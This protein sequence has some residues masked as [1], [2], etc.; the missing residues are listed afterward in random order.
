MKE[1][2]IYSIAVA[3][4]C[5][6]FS[7]VVQAQF[8]DKDMRLAEPIETNFCYDFGQGMTYMGGS[9]AV[10]GAGVLA[11]QYFHDRI[12]PD[13]NPATS[14]TS[15]LP[16]FG[17]VGLFTGGILAG[18]GTL[19][20]YKGN[21]RLD[22][23][24]GL[25]Y[26]GDPEGFATRFSLA[27]GIAHP[28][29]LNL[30]R[31]YQFNHHLFFGVGAGLQCF[32]KPAIPVYINLEYTPLKRRITPYM[33]GKLGGNFLFSDSSERDRMVVGYAGAEVGTR[34]RHRTK[35]AGKGDWS[36]AIFVETSESLGGNIGL[37]FG[38]SF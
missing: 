20:W 11:A 14:G 37:N 18:I 34:I 31:G 13:D 36:L 21:K 19:F 3:L 9:F 6:S 8:Q 17:Y 32:N 2:N 29:S 15:L 33:S 24:D 5:F 30:V 1:N 28:I 12:Y 7:T 4:L 38:Y 10:F 26:I 23:Q 25:Q 27:G 35:D 22:N 16:F